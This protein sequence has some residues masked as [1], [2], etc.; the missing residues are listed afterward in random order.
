MFTAFSIGVGTELTSG[1]ITNRNSTWISQKLSQLGVQT[2]AH[3]CVPDE[4][5]LIT[6]AFE[7][8]TKTAELIFVTGG[9]GPTSDDFTREVFKEWA[10]LEM[11]FSQESFEYLKAALESRSVPVRE[12]HR[13]ECYFPKGSTRLINTVGTAHGFY[14]AH[15][16]CHFFF[17][18]G[19]PKE[20]ESIWDSTLG[21]LIEKIVGGQDTLKVKSWDTIGLGESD[22]AHKVESALPHSKFEKAYRVHLPYVEFKLIYKG[23][24][25]AQANKDIELIEKALSPYLLRQT[26]AELN[27][28]FKANL[29]KFSHIYF[30]ANQNI[31]FLTK[32]TLDLLHPDFKSIVNWQI[33]T[34]ATQVPITNNEIKLHLEFSESGTKDELATATVVTKNGARHLNLKNPNPQLYRGNRAIQFFLESSLDFWNSEIKS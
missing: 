18:P 1:Q 6:Q 3:L 33:A 22:V 29:K 4:P 2:K 15:A 16:H 8:A 21:K 26:E 12:A 10:K 27:L 25:Q 31:T 7:L 24:D 34:D 13:Q 19:P 32:R 30:S 28:Q 14:S 20:I 11:E 23:S 9:L 17:L 5:H